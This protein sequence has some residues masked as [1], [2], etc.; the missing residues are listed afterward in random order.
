MEHKKTGTALAAL[1]A[2][3]ACA[4]YS[5][6]R[7]QKRR[8]EVQSIPKGAKIVIL[9]AGFAGIHVARELMRLI[10]PEK[11]ADIVLVDQNDFLLFTPMLTETAGGSVDAQHIVARIRNMAP[12]VRFQQGRVTSVDL[13]TKRVTIEVG[14]EDG[15]PAAMRDLEAD[16]LVIALG[17]CSNFRGT[18]GVQEHALTVKT[19]GDAAAIRGRIEALLER[20]T[21]EPDEEI[22]RALLTI[23]VAGGGYSGV[24][25]M[26]AVNDLLRDSMRDYPTLKP[27]QARTIL[28]DLG[29][30]LL[31]EL[32]EKLASYAQ[33]ELEHRGVAVRLKTGITG[34]GDGYVE[35]KGGE[36]IASHTLIWAAGV[37][38]SPIVE[39]LDITQGRHGGIIVDGSC[40]AQG[41]PGVWALG[42]CAEIPHPDGKGTYAPTAQNAMREGT[43][44]A[45]NIVAALRGEPTKPFV[46]T[47][48]GEMALVGRYTGV[49]RVFGLQ[50]SGPLAWAMWRCVYLAK[51]P[52][53][54]KR[55]RILA[56]WTLDAIFGREGA[57]SIA[58]RGARKLEAP[59]AYED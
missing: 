59:G 34:A 36:R 16:H 5:Y 19:V 45:R 44:T 29:D 58:T 33:R 49:A 43:L 3:G 13:E 7:M 56:D 20:A 53:L 46:Y 14:G 35:I 38:P 12:G 22:R 50:F 39:A 15:I 32:G 48:M 18:P 42:D 23:V 21:D 57:D 37:K 25:T 54:G 31:P 10:P 11:N 52:G 6:G 30:R 55:A 24:E 9:G 1:L 51:M 8:R 17:S 41:R 4:A 28:M 2:A 27:A 47:P 26:A 40:A